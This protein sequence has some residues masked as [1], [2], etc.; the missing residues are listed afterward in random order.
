[1]ADKQITVETAGGLVN[2]CAFVKRTCA[3]DLTGRVF[4]RLLVLGVVTPIPKGRPLKWMCRCSCPAAP[5]IAVR[6]TALTQGRSRSCG[7]LTREESSARAKRLGLGKLRVTHGMS[8]TKLF[9]RFH[10]MHER[11]EKPNHIGYK[12]YGA[13]GITVCERWSGEDGFANFYADMGEPPFEGASIDRTDSNGPYSPENC[14]WSSA[15]EQARNKRNSLMVRL[16]GERLSLIDLAERT[17]IA[18]STLYERIKILNWPVDEAV[19]TPP[20]FR[21]SGPQ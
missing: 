19:S 12:H 21:S 8:H 15:N 6:G 5:F 3:V 17:G 18:Y 2:Y 13:R 9:R 4:D 11:C 10:G 14:R 1:M 16:N 7:C 20:R